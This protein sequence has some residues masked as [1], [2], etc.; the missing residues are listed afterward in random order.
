MNYSVA[1]CDHPDVMF[2]QL[3]K[4]C[5]NSS[6]RYKANL[7]HLLSAQNPSQYNTRRLATGL[8]KQTI[9]SSLRH[10]LGVPN[11]FVMDLMHLTALNDPDLLLGLWRGTVKCYQPDTKDSWDWKVLTGKIW[12]SHGKTVAMATPYLPSS[13]CWVPR[14]PA[15]KINS[16]YKAW[17]SLIYLFG[18]G[19]ALLRSILPEK[20]WQNF[21]KLT[22]GIQVMYQLKLSPEQIKEGNHLLCEFHE[23][24]E[25]LY[26]Q[27]RAE[28]IHFLHH[29][30][31]LL[32][33]IGPETIHAGPLGCYAQWTMETAIGNLGDEIHQDKDPYANIVQC[34]LLHAQINSILSIMPNVLLSEDELTKVPWGGK[35]LGNG[36]ALL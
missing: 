9:F 35:D 25:D 10:S 6:E 3:H 29:G 21:C 8:S 1:G 23:E 26:V 17:E 19:P 20:Y 7:Q 33:H 18:L 16:G 12:E 24:F 36:Y 34:G 4:F 15:E 14:N 27:R 2:A 28:R 31:H 13:F 5:Q 11:I 22:R 32:T 30:I